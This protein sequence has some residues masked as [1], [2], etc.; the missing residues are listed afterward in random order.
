MYLYSWKRIFTHTKVLQ[1]YSY[2]H[3]STS[4]VL[5]LK[6]MYSTPSDEDAPFSYYPN[7]M[8]VFKWPCKPAHQIWWWKQY[9]SWWDDANKVLRDNL[10]IRNQKKTLPFQCHVRWYQYLPWTSTSCC[11]RMI[12]DSYWSMH[13]FFICLNIPTICTIYIR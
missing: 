7:E 2:S 6:K 8:Q 9:G 5:I 11:F 12:S 10:P 4:N 3:S 1:M 13:N